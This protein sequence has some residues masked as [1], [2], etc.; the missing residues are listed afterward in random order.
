MMWSETVNPLRRSLRTLF[1][2]ATALVVVAGCV[3]ETPPDPTVAPVH[4]KVTLNGKPLPQAFIMF[5][6]FE[7]RPSTGITDDE[8]N[9]EVI[10]D[11]KTK[12]ANIGGHRVRIRKHYNPMLV[13]PPKP[14]PDR[15]DAESELTRRVEPGDNVFNFDLIDDDSE[16]PDVEARPS[17]G[18]KT[19]DDPAP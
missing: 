11:H 7:S 4:G 9:Y 3:E 8:G 16:N 17:D 12:G 10:L 1:A 5:E 6:S 15:Y 19:I 13:S 14:L 18:P 2:S